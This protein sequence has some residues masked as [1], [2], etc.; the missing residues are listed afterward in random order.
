MR[1]ERS[2]RIYLLEAYS[3]RSKAC[4]LWVGVHCGL[5]GQILTM[6]LLASI[7]S[8]SDRLGSGSLVLSLVA[9]WVATIAVNN[10]VTTYFNSISQER[11]QQNERGRFIAPRVACDYGK[12]VSSK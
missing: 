10:I 9:A 6:A 8:L 12:T 11:L 2:A 1:Y 4:E 3:T 7:V 5:L